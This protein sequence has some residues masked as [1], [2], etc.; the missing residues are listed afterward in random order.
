MIFSKTHKKFCSKND[1]KKNNRLGSVAALV[2]GLE[3]HQILLSA[4]S[5]DGAEKRQTKKYLETSI[6]IKA[7]A[8]GGAVGTKFPGP[9]TFKGPGKA[10]H[11][12]GSEVSL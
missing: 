10:R 9:G 4:P 3:P 5:L 8:R 1:E 2:M 11:I 6:S 7:G 12:T